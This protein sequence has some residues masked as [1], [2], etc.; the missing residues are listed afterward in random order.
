MTASGNVEVAGNVVA[1]YFVGDGSR[2]TGISGGSGGTSH[3][4]KDAVTNQLHYST[5]SVGI[6]NT[7]PAHDLSVGSNLYVD[8]DAT[9]GV[10]MVTGNV[11]GT[12]FVGDG[13]RLI[14]LPE[15]G[16]STN[17]TTSG[18]PVNKIYY[19][20]NPGTTSVSVGIMNA[21]PTHTLSVGSNLFIDDAGSNVLH[22]D[23]NITA[24]SMF[25]GALG[26]KPAYPLDSVTDTG[27]V[28]P[29]TISFT[30]PTLGITTASNVEIGGALVVGKGT[31]GGSNL[32]VGEA[33]LFVNTEL[34]R[35]GIATDQP[36]ATLHVNGS[37]A[38]DGPLT[39]GTVDVAAQHGLE[40]ITAVDNTTPLTIEL[41]NAD[42]SL[43]TTG[44]VEVG[45]NVITSKDLTVTGNVT[46]NSEL[47]VAG[48]V[49]YT[50]LM[51]VSVKSNVVTEYTGPHDRPLR[52]YPEVALS[53]TSESASGE[54]GYKVSWSSI[55][56]NGNN[57][58]E[59]PFRAFDGDIGNTGNAW[60][61]PSGVY[62]S[63]G[64][65][66]QNPPR[67]L[68]T[69]TGGNST[70]VD[71]EYI[72]L[73]TPNK[74][75]VKHFRISDKSTFTGRAAE[76]GK[77]Y[78]SND[79]STWYELASFSELTYYD[80]SDYFN[81]V[82]VNATTYYDRLAL[83]VTN[84]TATSSSTYMGIGELEYYGYEEG[85]G[86]LDTT[87]KTVF[88]VP[89]TTGTQLEVYYDGQDYTA[90]TDFD[91]ANEV[92][93]KSGN[94]LHGSQNGGVGFDSTYKAFTFDGVDDKITTT[95]IGNTVGD[96]THSTSFWFK[97]DVV[98]SI[99][100]YS[101]GPNT[102]S[103]QNVTALYYN[104]EGNYLQTS[105]SGGV[106]NRFKNVT[107]VPNHWYHLTTVKRANAQD[108]IYLNGIELPVTEYGNT[109]LQMSLPANTSLNIGARP[110]QPSVAFFDGSIANF[111]LYSKA[112]NAGQV[113]ELY[114]FQ[115]DYF[116]GSKSQVTL[117][118]GHLGVGVTEPSGQL[119]LAGD[120]RIQEYPPGPM[121]DYDTHIPGHGVIKA[122]A[123]TD[124]EQTPYRS[125]NAFDKTITT[126]GGNNNGWASKDGT[127]LNDGTTTPVS[128]LADNFDGV[129]CHWL[130]LQLPYEVKPTL[131]TLQARNDGQV[132]GE[133]PAKGRIYGSK[134]GVTWNQ[135]R[136]YDIRTEVGTLQA[137]TDNAPIPITLTTNEYYTHL[138]LTVD[139]RY[140][141][142]GTARWTG[143]GELRY[144]GTPGPTTL[145]KG[146]LSLTRSLD[147]P[148]VSRYDVDTETPRPE[149]LVV[150]FDTTVNSSPTDISGKGNHGVMT[151][152][153]SYSAPDKA[154]EG[155]SSTGGRRIEVTGVPTATGSG[156]FTLT[157]SMWFKLKTIPAVGTSRVLWGMVGENDGTDGSPSS[158][159][160]PHAIVDASG[161]ISWA[162]WGNDIYNQTAIVADRWYHCIWTYSG[163]TTG[164][165]MILDGVEQTF[166]IAQTAALNMR[167]ATSRLT[168]GIYPHDLATS[169]LDGYVSNFKLY[170]VALEPS[171]VKKLYN[172]GRTGRSMV[173]SDTAV[174]IGKVPEANLDVR[175]TGKF[176][177]IGVN[178]DNL[179]GALQV[180]QGPNLVFGGTT[181]TIQDVVP[182][183]VI[184]SDSAKW[185]M[186]IN[187]NDDLIFTSH[188]SLSGTYTGVTGYIL[189]GAYDQRMND[190]TGQHRC[191]LRG[192][193]REQIK[194]KVGL[195]VS[196]DKNKYTMISG[197]IITGQNAIDISES[198]PDV[199]ISSKAYDKA[200]FGVISDVEDPEKREDL[201][202]VFG[203]PFPKEKGDDRVYINS[204]GEGAIWVVNTNGSLEAGDY[205]TTSNVAGYGQ[206]QDGAGLMNYTVAKI[207]M[208]CDFNPATQPI[209]VIRKDE[210]GENILDEH[211][212]IQWEDD[213][214]E[215][216]KAYKLRYLAV[217]G[218]QTDEANA[219]H[220]AAFVGC[221]YH[222]G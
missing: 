153:F 66:A 187:G 143:I 18:N 55:Y 141:G 129:E 195:I 192:I 46:T 134:D 182:G 177:G 92:L 34:T 58:N 23:G 67:N 154:F 164:R 119:E 107:L 184:S 20:Q 22:V 186:F 31:L 171:E 127:W 113:K 163:G 121:D 215:T 26:I 52:K 83:V 19:P 178:T 89:A 7:N 49:F 139:E 160:A 10:L 27:N 194:D 1:T 112:L 191:F 109:G 106:Y 4:T 91:Q 94:N 149:K 65:Y 69:A 205:I 117:Y 88:N 128:S 21:A 207:T 212:Q 216:E 208:D 170:N 3:W 36:A 132:P 217:D 218:T 201:Y 60:M 146:S 130:A 204:V 176:Q 133:V 12:Y 41:Q 102:V 157:V 71:G 15:G 33:N 190:F 5:G 161:N 82:H 64:T 75:K 90:D 219:V 135:I 44:N 2:L 122:Y 200:C 125:W 221:T 189:E 70:T 169:A 175:G 193:P 110:D 13:S 126:D 165:K 11:H 214:T 56:D 210:T 213:P 47:I 51:S 188:D 185:A 8:D 30:N 59:R 9:D 68:G 199:S 14:N 24:E 104:V 159:S 173:I 152:G 196:S 118:K 148:R 142:S 179:I 206:K 180:H 39:F 73:Q 138:L 98:E 183:F 211:G 166:N 63:D 48:N 25:L 6:S 35:V 74:I 96:W 168:I 203:T 150:D 124:Y 162:M 167:N 95:S 140:G 144:F 42:T 72:I 76:A 105:V 57:V 80:A 37:L 172:L 93:D 155:D 97:F 174:G 101:I 137:S 54:N 158:Y 198:I 32:E 16:G 50:N 108:S 131:V 87:L 136:S 222:C 197:D 156:N 99:H 120:E 45:G 17:W 84:S 86:S 78:G 103:G 61:V 79:G 43:V 111:R 28:T 202:G 145:D 115:K 85:S 53:I 29:H 40:A 116:L 81:T 151:S 147:V 220:T 114:D 181:A 38:V 209:Q 77:L 100:F 62:G 123:S